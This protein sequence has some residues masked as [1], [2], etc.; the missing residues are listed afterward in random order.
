MISK[1]NR[2]VTRSRSQSVSSEEVEVRL[3]KYKVK[4]SKRLNHP[5]L[6]SLEESSDITDSTTIKKASQESANNKL[7]KRN[8]RT[9]PETKINILSK[10]VYL[11]EFER[12]QVNDFL[13]SDKKILYVSGQ[14]GT[15]KTS[16][17]YEIMQYRI[18]E[19]KQKYFYVNINCFTSLRSV[20]EVYT[21]YFENLQLHAESFNNDELNELISQYFDSKA[22]G[23]EEYKRYFIESIKILKDIAT[24]LIM[25]DEID[26]IYDK[27]RQSS[28]KKALLFND[29][30][31]I[32]YISSY[33]VKLIMIS[34]NTEFE[35]EI[36]SQL[37]SKTTYIDK[38][39]FEPYTSVTILSILEYMLKENGLHKYFS[40]EALLFLS[41][42]CCKSCGDIRKAINCVQSVLLS[43]IQENTVD[44]DIK[45]TTQKVLEEL[46]SVESVVFKSLKSLTSEQK[47]VLIAI[48]EVMKRDE[49]QV[50]INEK[51]I[52]I[53]YKEI[54]AKRY[55]TLN[56]SERIYNEALTALK[57]NG[58]IE[59]KQSK[60]KSIV[61]MIKFTVQE[62]SQT[63]SDDSIFQLINNEIKEEEL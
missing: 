58:F 32:P 22:H 27:Q 50:E 2:R 56:S 33:P 45:I 63:F 26:G 52:L 36:F 10:A 11:R 14:P 30:L 8:S 12:K 54:K 16:L 7:S 43:H 3:S 25:L 35:K 61:K 19:Q 15:G 46:K 49:E 4:D 13:D 44:T 17:L 24:P 38:V 5:K 59:T 51:E 1:K 57:E 34:N 55:Q 31:K 53:K 18:N 41:R 48:Y 21:T 40:Q 37:Q 62:L 39:V 9:A 47:I 42:K 28:N 20:T 60:T 23:P 6:Y 29:L